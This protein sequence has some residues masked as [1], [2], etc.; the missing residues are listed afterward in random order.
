MRQTRGEWALRF[1]VAAAFAAL[2]M[3]FATLGAGC[4]SETASYC[5]ARCDCQG[6]S[7]RDREDCADDV[8]DAER[9]AEFDGC[10]AEYSSYVTCYVDEGT[11]NGGAF[12]A[13]SCAPKVD[14]LRGCSSRSA[15]FIK[16]ACQEERE[17]RASCGLSGG[18]AVPCSGGDECVAYCA[19]AASCEDLE[20]PQTG[21]PYVDCAIACSE[22][23]SSSG[24]GP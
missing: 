14:T 23:G 21:T 15:T 3:A 9:L 24:G 7:Q 8:E 2:S 11:C 16:T 20:N 1:S 17:K 18:G 6:C 12:I 13:S 10:A 5:S 4:E 19:L 22:S